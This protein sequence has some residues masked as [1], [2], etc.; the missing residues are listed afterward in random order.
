M[1]FPVNLVLLLCSVLVA[2]PATG[3][4]EPA[5]AVPPK[6]EILDAV[7]QSYAEHRSFHGV[8][9][10][11]AGGDVVYERAFGYGNLEWKA[12][13]TA[14]TAFRIA[15]ITKCFTAVLVMQQVEIGRLRLDGPVSE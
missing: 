15:S 10:A 4:A 13:N 6:A 8:V 5:A 11:A 12:P 7:M 1:K 9:L 2:V 3:L 14:D